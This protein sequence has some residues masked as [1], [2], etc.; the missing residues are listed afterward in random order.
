[1]RGDENKAISDYSRALQINLYKADAYYNRGNSRYA[2]GDKHGAIA[3]YNIALEINPDKA[4]AYYNRGEI[5]YEFC[6]R[7]SPTNF[8]RKRRT[9]SISIKT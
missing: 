8:T 9:E 4:D 6:F 3:D 5:G 7:Q 1:M 2:L